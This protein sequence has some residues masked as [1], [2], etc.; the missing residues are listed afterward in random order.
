V[1]NPVKDPLGTKLYY[2]ISEVAELTQLP[3]YTLR[4]WEK[5]F[6]CLRPR[7]ARGKNRAYR[8]RDIR[9]ILLI[10]SL[11]HD[12]RYT[13]Q[14]VKQKLL[15]EPELLHGVGFDPAS[16]RPVQMVLEVTDPKPAADPGGAAAPGPSAPA[17]GA[18]TGALLATVRE[19]L[20]AL[21]EL[22]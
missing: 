20:R 5:E 1:K 6:T 3:S 15:N 13:M 14:G 11:L 18:Q 17:P 12:E 19:E 8:E 9:V 21:L 22:L 7:R 4:A 16:A 10:K 2:S